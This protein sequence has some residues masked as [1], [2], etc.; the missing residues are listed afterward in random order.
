M[1]IR[2]LLAASL[3][4][5]ALALVPT[6]TTQAQAEFVAAFGSAAPEGTPWADLLVKLKDE[7][8]TKT[9][10]RVQIKTFLGS[11]LG[12]EPPLE[13]TAFVPLDACHT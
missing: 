4:L 13:A 11:V 7:V 6:K 10:G 12:G 3:G 2:T 5:T 9:G 1:R 8:K